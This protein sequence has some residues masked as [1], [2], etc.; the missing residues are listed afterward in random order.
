MKKFFIFFFILFSSQCYAIT[1]GEIV[2]PLEK[3]LDCRNTSVWYEQEVCRAINAE[4]VPRLANANISIVNGDIVFREDPIATPGP[5]N[6]GHS[7]SHRAWLRSNYL[8]AKVLSSGSLDLDFNSISEPLMLLFRAPIDIYARADIKEEWGYRFLGSCNKSGDDRYHGDFSFSG[9]GILKVVVSLEPNFKRSSQGDIFVLLKPF[10]DVKVGMEDV[11][12]E[13]DFHG[14]SVLNG[15]AT[16]V[17]GAGSSLLQLRPSRF[18]D[19]DETVAELESLGISLG[20]GAVQ[21]LDSVSDNILDIDL[22]DDFL[23]S[24]AIESDIEDLNN[25]FADISGSIEQDIFDE[26]SGALNLDENGQ[27]YYLFDANFNRK[28]IAKNVWTSYSTPNRNRNRN[29]QDFCPNGGFVSGIKIKETWGYGVTDMMLECVDHEGKR[30]LSNNWITKN[31]HYNRQ[32]T[33]SCGSS[34]Q[35]VSVSAQEQGGYGVIDTRIHCGHSSSP[36]SASMRSG[37]TG[38]RAGGLR[39]APYCPNNQ[40]PVGIQVSEQYG[41]GVVNYRLICNNSPCAAFLG[42]NS[43]PRIGEIYPPNRYY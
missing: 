6:T 43:D 29:L 17:F 1:I 18:Q 30:Q 32:Y 33:A 24:L 35:L 12:A 22:F 11:S 15:L 3:Y 9:V 13:F 38:N 31:S 7:C 16:T 10:V 42:D 2:N 26:L 8:T 27:V 23:V 39:K 19:L 40:R 36:Q 41:Y 20:L 4:I 28:T 21:T 14:K 25:S 34:S 37:M 5:I